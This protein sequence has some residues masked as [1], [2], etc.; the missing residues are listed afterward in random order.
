MRQ[1]GRPAQISCTLGFKPSESALRG[2]S[3]FIIV[4]NNESH[5][6]EATI[7]IRMG[8]THDSKAPSKKRKTYQASK[9]WATEFCMLWLLEID[10]LTKKGTNVGVAA[11][12]VRTIPQA[13]ILNPRYFATGKYSAIIDVGI[14]AQT[15]PN[16]LVIVLNW[17]NSG[18]N[19]L[20][21]NKNPA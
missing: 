4:E 5:S 6:Q 15:L 10:R 13:T 9:D 12:Q 17:I 20:P 8:A 16:V 19:G 7:K 21:Q 14:S 2:Q 11:K 3:K 1:Y 18:R